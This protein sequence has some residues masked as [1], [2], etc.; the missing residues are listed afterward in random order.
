MIRQGE[1]LHRRSETPGCDSGCLAY[2][3]NPEDYVERE[4][5]PICPW[6]QE[7][8]NPILY[9]LLDFINMLDAGC[10]VGRH[11][12]TD[13]EWRALARIKAERDKIS[14]EKIKE[15]EA[16]GLKDQKDKRLKD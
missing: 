8:S 4:I 11:E 5:C 16:K 1:L 10:P 15:K 7:I 13:F 12:M 9:R 2:E 14:I 3:E 6:G